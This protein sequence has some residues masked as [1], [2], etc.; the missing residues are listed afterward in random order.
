VRAVL[1]T[2]ESGGTPVLEFFDR[3]GARRMELTGAV[4]PRLIMYDPEGRTVLE[5]IGA[6]DSSSVSL[7][8]G[9]DDE[10]ISLRVNHVEPRSRLLHISDGSGDRR[11]WLGSVGQERLRLFI[12]DEDGKQAIVETK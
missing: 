6:L 2:I 10:H 12:V 1:R 5:I 9:F 11:A 4:G 7:M 3:D 8:S